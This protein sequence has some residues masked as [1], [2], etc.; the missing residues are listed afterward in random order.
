M[1][2][3]SCHAL[4][5]GPGP[6]PGPLE[7][8]DPIPKFIV[9][10]KDSQVWQIRG[11]WFQIRQKFLKILTQ[12]YPNEAFLVPNLGILFFHET[13]HLAKFKGADLKYDNSFLKILAQK[14]LTKAF[15]VTK[16]GIFILSR[17]FAFIQIRG[18]YFKYHNSFS[19]Y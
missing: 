17:N 12:K 19:K 14:Y 9:W 4:Q 15:W 3:F 5:S 2:S 13:L 1:H 18:C 7:K 16:L 10:V 11:C 8:A 6:G